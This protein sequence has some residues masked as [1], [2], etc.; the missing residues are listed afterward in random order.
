MINQ[1]SS[2]RTITSEYDNHFALRGKGAGCSKSLVGKVCIVTF[3]VH[4]AKSAWSKEDVEKCKLVMQKVQSTLQSQSGLSKNRLHIAY[5]VDVVSVQLKF[6]RDFHKELEE[7]VLKQY[8]N[9]NDSA[10]YQEHYEK[11]FLKDEAPVIFIL[12]R[13]FRSFAISSEDNSTVGNEASYVSFS[14]D[15]EACARTVMHELLH[16]FGAIDLYLPEKV[17][18]SS[19]KHF[20]N[21]IMNSGD[22]IDSLTRYLIGW[23]EEPTEEV[24]SFLQETKEITEEEIRQAYIKDKD[25]DW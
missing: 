15:I 6:D 3:L 4:E 11:K 7:N 2:E 23:D 18:I 20:P 22:Q 13:D 9:Y 12:N 16:Q 19:E 14:D 1:E 25:N 24:L 5:A 8:G 10:S 21:S 17:K